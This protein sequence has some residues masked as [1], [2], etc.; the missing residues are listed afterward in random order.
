MAKGEA[1]K[2]SKELERMSSSVEEEKE[3]Q[4]DPEKIKEVFLRLREQEDKAYAA[5]RSLEKEKKKIKLEKDD[6]KEVM[7][8][9]DLTREEAMN[10]LRDGDSNGN[11]EACF[12]AFINEPCHQPFVETSI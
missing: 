5:K 7:K 2:Q 12:N 10:A 3:I 4:V 6:I 9:L 11:I 8:E 1:A